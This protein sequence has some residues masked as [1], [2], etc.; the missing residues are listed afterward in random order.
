MLMLLLAPLTN[1]TFQVQGKKTQR[2]VGTS[3]LSGESQMSNYE[4][5]KYMI[6]L[7]RA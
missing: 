4:C 1:G 5:Y 3:Q 2:K 6:N 7:A